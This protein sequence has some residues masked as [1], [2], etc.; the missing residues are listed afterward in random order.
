[1]RLKKHADCGLPF[2]T[3]TFVFSTKNT[4]TNANIRTFA[5]TVV[6]K[7]Q[8]I[9]R[10]VIT[11]CPPY[12]PTKNFGKSACK[13]MAFKTSLAPFT[14]TARSLCRRLLQSCPCSN[15]FNFFIVA[16]PFGICKRFL[17][18]RQIFQNSLSL[19]LKNML[20]K[21]T[22]ERFSHSV[23]TNLSSATSKIS[24]SGIAAITGECVQIT[25]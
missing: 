21:L 1:M 12:L 4:L 7:K 16:N 25:N 24:A 6:L 15:A 14:K 10:S 3:S 9:P 17:R 2:Q 8:V 22:L 19:F 23:F 20:I 18:N 5:C 13:A 11:D